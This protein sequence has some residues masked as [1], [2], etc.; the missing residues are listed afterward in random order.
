MIKIVRTFVI[1][2]HSLGVAIN[3]SPFL[4]PNCAI[5]T[6]NDWQTSDF[7]VSVGFSAHPALASNTIRKIESFRKPESRK[8]LLMRILGGKKEK[9][10]KEKEEESNSP[11]ELQSGQ[12]D[13]LP[14]ANLVESDGEGSGF[15]QTPS[16]EDE[17]QENQESIR[18]ELAVPFQNDIESSSGLD[19][20]ESNVEK[21]GDSGDIDDQES[22]VI[23]PSFVSTASSS[24]SVAVSL[25]PL[26][27]EV[28]KVFWHLD[29]NYL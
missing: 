27:L 4:A 2:P 7:P 12:S 28:R 20:K 16:L 24:S 15:D 3:K 26:E 29:C 18:S 19:L 9:E 17:E 22:P 8:Q 5:E 1:K 14:P 10:G 23:E 21:R 25:S 13:P 11:P 6:E